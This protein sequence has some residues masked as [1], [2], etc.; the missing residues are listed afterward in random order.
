MSASKPSYISYEELRVSKLLSGLVSNKILTAVRFGACASVYNPI[1]TVAELTTAQTLILALFY[2][3]L[4]TDLKFCHF[5]QRLISKVDQLK[6]PYLSSW[7]RDDHKFNTSDVYKVI[8]NLAHLVRGQHIDLPDYVLRVFVS[9]NSKYGI[10]DICKTNKDLEAF[11]FLMSVNVPCSR[12]QQTDKISSPRDL[13]FWSGLSPGFDNQNHLFNF[14]PKEHLINGGGQHVQ[15]L[16]NLMKEP[17]NDSNEESNLFQRSRSS[18]TS[19]QSLCSERSTCTDSRKPEVKPRNSAKSRNK[20][21][22]RGPNPKEGK[23]LVHA[24]STPNIL[25]PSLKNDE[26]SQEAGLVQSYLS[27][28]GSAP[29]SVSQISRL[30]CKRDGKGGKSPLHQASKDGLFAVVKG[31]IN[32]GAPVN[33]RDDVGFTP[34][35]YAA[36][37]GYIEILEVLKQHKADLTA[38]GD[39]GDSLLHTAARKNHSGTCGWLL[40][41]G[42]AIDAQGFKGRTALHCAAMWGFMDTVRLLL[43]HKASVD[44]KDFYHNTAYD[45][46]V[47]QGHPQIARILK[48]VCR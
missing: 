9:L 4:S 10:V 22:T 44:I 34:A 18:S 16:N 45:L 32:Y 21:R 27:R 28:T 37:G 7:L 2:G 8:S 13:S 36:R 40:D 43:A 11:Y 33:C 12:S 14:G 35:H 24:V 15:T 42:V 46:A 19:N 48:N 6:S 31:L 47:S 29:V 1:L 30:V 26:I 5:L 17:F 25:E 38:V 23:S 39:S 3:L 41:N 20:S